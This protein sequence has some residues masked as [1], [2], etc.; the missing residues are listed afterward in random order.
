MCIREEA[1]KT[2]TFSAD[3]LDFFLDSMLHS[4]SV[5]QEVFVNSIFRSFITKNPAFYRELYN[6]L[7]ISR[8]IYCSPVWRPHHAK[9]VHLLESVR[10]RFVKRITWRCGCPEVD[11]PSV[12]ELFDDHDLRMYRLLKREELIDHYICTRPNSLRSGCSYSPKVTARSDIVNNVYSWRICR[13][14]NSKT[15]FVK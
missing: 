5:F 2:R 6:S 15:P 14:L 13:V 4:R 10:K 9:Y 3:V 12:S 8:L 11:I 1:R 7:V